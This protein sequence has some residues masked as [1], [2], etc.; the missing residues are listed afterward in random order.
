[1][2]RIRKSKGSEVKQLPVTVTVTILFGA[3]HFVFSTT[4]LKITSLHSELEYLL[5]DVIST[6]VTVLCSFCSMVIFNKM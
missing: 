2:V 4:A 5:A 6:S 3:V 1:M